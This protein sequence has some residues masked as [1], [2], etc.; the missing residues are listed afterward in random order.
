[1]RH[2][3]LLSFLWASSLPTLVHSYFKR[4]AAE[5]AIY[6]MTYLQEEVYGVNNAAAYQVAPNCKG[7]RDGFL[8]QKN[9]CTL[10]EFL[11]HIWAQKA[12]DAN[13]VKPDPARLTGTKGLEDVRQLTA[14][15]IGSY[16][17]GAQQTKPGGG[18]EPVTKMGYYGEVDPGKLLRG[19]TSYWDALGRFGLV[20]NEAKRRAEE[21]KRNGGLDDKKFAQFEKWNT[22]AK[23]ATNTA[24]ALRQ[25]VIWEFQWSHVSD[26]KAKIGVEPVKTKVTSTAK[27]GG[28]V[29]SWDT[30]A[31]D[32]TIEKIQTELGLN[33]VDAT[34]RFD[35]GWAALQADT[36]T[37]EHISSLEAVKRIQRNLGC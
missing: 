31:V 6:Y 9:R 12:N 24:V 25:Q 19:A 8:G 23:E 29:I 28:Q 17:M 27:W 26:M 22:Q 35:A 15:K 14:D 7:T 13:D 5:R 30:I 36:N 2:Q 32:K 11:N 20:S 34:K 37:A 3:I 16:I 21:L 18:T 1:M 33:K 10:I 4:G